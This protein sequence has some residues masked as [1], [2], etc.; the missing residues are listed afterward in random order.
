MSRYIYEIASIKKHTKLTEADSLRIGRRVFIGT[1]EEGCRAI[2]PH[3]DNEE[4]YLMTSRVYT[5]TNVNGGN[6]IVFT[7]KNTTYS[8]RKV[9][10]ND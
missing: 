5:V 3:A 9:S 7:T 8:L 6:D 4:K 1:L 10:E 2:L